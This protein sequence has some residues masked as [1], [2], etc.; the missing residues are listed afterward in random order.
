MPDIRERQMC[1]PNTCK[2]C[3]HCMPLKEYNP[4]SFSSRYEYYCM[5]GA[6]DEAREYVHNEVRNKG[7]YAAPFEYSYELLQIMR[8][9]DEIIQDSPRYVEPYQCCQFFDWKEWINV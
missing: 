8:M 4:E 1:P 2:F 7:L 5:L 6:S 3:K 9:P